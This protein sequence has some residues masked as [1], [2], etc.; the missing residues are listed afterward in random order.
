MGAVLIDIMETI[1][2][3][4]YYGSCMIDTCIMLAVLIDTCIMVAVLIDTCIMVA[5]LIDT[6]VD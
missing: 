4:L 3:Y 5:V 6:Y 1:F 2:L